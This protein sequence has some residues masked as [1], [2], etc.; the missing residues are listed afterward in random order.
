MRKQLRRSYLLL[1]ALRL[2]FVVLFVTAVLRMDVRSDQASLLTI[3]NTARGWTGEALS[4][5]PDLARKIAQNETSLHVSFLL[6]NGIVLG[7]SEEDLPDGEALLQNPAVQ[8]AL[9]AG[10]GQDMS[11][12]PLLSPQ[13]FAAGMLGEGQMI[14]HLR[15]QSGKILTILRF[16]IPGILLLA[17]MVSVSAQLSLR[18]V[19]RRLSHQLSQ[20]RG[21]L[22]G[23]IE[24]EHIDASSF[25][26]ELAPAMENVLRLIDRMRYD[27]QQ[28]QGARDMQRDFVNNTSHE[29]KSPLTSILGFAQMLDE[30]ENLEPEKRAQYLGHILKDSERMLAVIENILQL[31]RHERPL[32]KEMTP[33]RLRTIAPEVGRSLQ[34]QCQQHGI[35]I[36]V[37]GELKLRVLEQDMRDLLRNLMSNAVRYGREKGQVWVEMAGRNLVVRDD[38]LGIAEEHLPRIFEKFYRADKA[39]SRGVDGTGLGLSIVAGI[40]NR[41]GASI[42][43]DSREGEGSRFALAFPE[44]LMEAS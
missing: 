24:R 30:D 5:L 10:I 41:Y 43:V 12:Q 2:L 33:V 7:H 28:I 27:L 9:V 44:D 8:R 23:V 20:I 11:W 34:P 32:P 36:H 3:L 13:F 14:L 39:L 35:K 38:G 22:E 26:P 1:I 42:H 37:S 40:V 29:L 21:L 17:L 31:Q 19:M 15:Y 25:Y 16:V 4:S 6:P 18:S